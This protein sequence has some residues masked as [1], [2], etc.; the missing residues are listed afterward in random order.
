MT[1][2]P[3]PKTTQMF[4][5]V[6]EKFHI[7]VEPF[8][9]DKWSAG[10]TMARALDTV[11]DDDHRYDTTQYTEQVLR[12]KSV[13]HLTD[14]EGEFIRATFDQLSDQSK[15]RWTNAATLL[16]AFAL[17]RLE[18]DTINRYIDVVREESALMADVVKVENNLER[19]DHRQRQRFN[20][21][22]TP[23]VQ[24]FF[25]FDT[26]SDFIKDH[27]EGN[28]N[29]PITS[30][31]VRHLARYAVEEG[32]TLGRITPPL[33]YPV[34]VGRAV[35]KVREKAKQKGFWAKQFIIGQSK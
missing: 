7:D 28:M 33:I 12:G 22:L 19:T 11:V 30:Y 21:W 25:V 13:P 14:E 24:S 26:C 31:A 27:N 17:K 32:I 20:N 16:G 1:S 35:V 6:A 10:L 29:L 18:A 9:K 23:A 5:G 3:H 8:D 2:R 4:V 34:L 15:E